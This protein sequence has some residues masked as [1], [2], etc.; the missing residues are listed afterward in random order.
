[1]S[2]QTSIYALLNQ[3]TKR[4]WYHAQ[5]REQGN[6]E[7]ARRRERQSILSSVE[8]IRNAYFFSVGAH[9]WTIYGREIEKYGGKCS[10]KLQGYGGIESADIQAAIRMGVPGYDNSHLEFTEGFV[11]KVYRAPLV[12]DTKDEPHEDGTYGSMSYAPATYLLAYWSEAGA[13]IYG[14]NPKQSD[15]DLAATALAG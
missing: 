3:D 9:G 15:L 6:H 4:W 7:E 1:M 11:K 12:S 13:D 10:S 8:T 5:L 14:S 2:Q